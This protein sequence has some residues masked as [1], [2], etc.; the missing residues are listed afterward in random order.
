MAEPWADEY[1][2]ELARRKQRLQDL[3]TRPITEEDKQALRE[4]LTAREEDK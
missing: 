3:M 2:Q 4:L 1:E